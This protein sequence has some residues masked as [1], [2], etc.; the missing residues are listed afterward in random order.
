MRTDY[1]KQDSFFFR[2]PDPLLSG[3]I[4][5][6]YKRFLADI[7]LDNGQIVTCHVA[8]SGSMKTCWEPGARAVV[9]HQTG[10]HGRKLKYSLQAVQMPDGWVGVNTMN[11]NKVVAGAISS[12]VIRELTGYKFMQTETMVQA[13]SR[14]DIALFA[15]MP[16]SGSIVKMNP[17]RITAIGQSSGKRVDT[18]IVEVK[19]ATLLE[20]NG[21]IFP[22]AKT[23]RG[24]KHLKHLMEMKLLGY[25]TII[26]FFA[27]RTGAKWVGP[28]DEI[29]PEYGKLLRQA[30]KSGVEALA[31]EVKVNEKGLAIVGSIPL[32]L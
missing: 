9:T 14:F 21:V 11:P 6:R 27:G 12:G 5:Q 28:A 10:N 29:D 17:K 4:Q 20:K 22:D 31:L 1:N 8:N 26:L 32:K 19:N 18:C 13:G 23:E 15:E 16:E 25:R 2:F 3:R 7:K 24:Q 30:V